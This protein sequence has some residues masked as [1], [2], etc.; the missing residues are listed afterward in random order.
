MA[1]SH[2]APLA[3]SLGAVISELARF[4]PHGYGRSYQVPRFIT[5]ETDS[6]ELVDIG[7]PYSF[8]IE[9]LT[10]LSVAPDLTLPGPGI[11]GNDFLYLTFLRSFASLNGEIGTPLKQIAFLPHLQ[12]LGV[13]VLLSLPTGV[14]GK[15]NRKGDRGSPFAVK[16]PFKVD[17][18]LADT[19]IPDLDAQ[20]QYIAMVACFEAVGIRCGSIV[21]LATHSIDSSI[22]AQFPSTT[23]W[24]NRGLGHTLRPSRI[25]DR[26]NS[27]SP[28]TVGGMSDED[29]Q[30]FEQPPDRN[31][32]RAA[33]SA[34][35]QYW[36][37]NSGLTPAP[38][39]PDVAPDDGTYS[40]GDVAA[41]RY[42]SSP[43][44]NLGPLEESADLSPR[45][46]QI[47]A[48]CVASRAINLGERIFW[49]DV[50]ERVPD[51]VLQM[52]AQ[53]V[54]GWTDDSSALCE[55]LAEGADPD[56]ID[57]LLNSVVEALPDHDIDHQVTFIA[58][59]LFTFDP[60]GES[61]DAIVGPW[62]FCVGPF[63]HDP[64]TL[65]QSM[66]HHV[67]LL[68]ETSPRVPFLAGLGDH[69]SMPPDR[70]HI[71]GL[72]TTTFLLPSSIPFLFS[73]VEHGSELIV[74]KEFGFN[75]TP[76]LQA[77]RNQL[78]DD[79]L[80]LF[81]DVPLRW[82]ELTPSGRIL[83]VIRQV[84]TIRRAV[85]DFE[86]SDLTPVTQD[87]EVIGYER[88]NGNSDY[89]AVHFNPST[90]VAK[91]VT[92]DRNASIVFSAGPNG[93]SHSSDLTRHPPL[94]TIVT[95]TRRV[96]EAIRH[97]RGLQ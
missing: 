55:L 29:S 58:E 30:Q 37:T 61:H 64:L 20:T 33:Q 71:S 96:E 72:L 18:S 3:D 83:P 14:I 21:P 66:N 6:T 23:Y 63:T 53:L 9:R 56:R 2:A 45:S 92:H 94:T 17:S 5:E 24:W 19:L 77:L 15:A 13:T 51:S 60:P 85:V 35:H 47:M 8:F 16:N 82:S 43:T 81:N 70:N 87:G 62:V 48:L 31:V 69:D 11:H 65:R 41:V 32:I 36:Q 42:D 34:G 4:E 95:A 78:T 38:A 90:D 26:E 73:G 52:A 75:T 68:A 80:P 1:S 7:N 91:Q 40:W 76:E 93:P 67:R 74:N 97:A 86:L 59:E 22:I 88:S 50:A 28:E 46:I 79:Q 25:E 27:G 10:T 49:I 54:A 57:S 84:L 89:L 39:C 44:P 12:R